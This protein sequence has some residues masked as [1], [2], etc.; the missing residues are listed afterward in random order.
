MLG[1]KW[2]ILIL[3]A[4]FGAVAEAAADSTPSCSTEVQ[5]QLRA[6]LGNQSTALLLDHVFEM[7]KIQSTIARGIS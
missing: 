5:L 7:R 2:L 3:L 6:R 1:S 4:T